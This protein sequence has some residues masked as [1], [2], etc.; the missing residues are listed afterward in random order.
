MCIS[1]V[2]TMDPGCFTGLRASGPCREDLD[3][4]SAD[5]GS[6]AGLRC[7]GRHV[8]V[9]PTSTSKRTKWM[10]NVQ[11]LFFVVDDDVSFPKKHELRSF[12]VI[13]TY[14]MLVIVLIW[15]SAFLWSITFCKINQKTNSSDF[16]AFLPKNPLRSATR[17]FKFLFSMVWFPTNRQVVEVDSSD[18]EEMCSLARAMPKSQQLRSPSVHCLAAM[19]ILFGSIFCCFLMFCCSHLWDDFV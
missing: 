6:L 10:T 12:M 17:L 11:D 1:I 14:Y 2:A 4:G 16:E 9:A 13:V 19:D 5:H 7:R 3:L 8:R 15:L 18:K